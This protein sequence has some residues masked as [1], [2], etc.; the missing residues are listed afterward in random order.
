[1]KKDIE[2]KITLPEDVEAKQ[3]GNTLIIKG[4]KGETKR[5]FKIPHA[6]ITLKGKE[7]IFKATKATKIESKN[8]FTTIAH[9]NNMIYGVKNPY[10]FKLKICNSHFPMN[11]AVSGSKLIIKNFLGEKYPRELELGT[12]VKVKVNGDQITVESSDIEEAGKTASN[13]EQISRITGRDRRVFQDGIYITE[14]GER[15]KI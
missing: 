8:I 12:Q 3:E 14:K 7:I 11:V 4:P 10:I 13:I 5:A 6:E 2:R 9:I 15:A 1:M